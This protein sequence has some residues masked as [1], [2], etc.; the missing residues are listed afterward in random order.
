ML[1]DRDYMRQPEYH[2]PRVSWTIVLLVVNFVVFLVQLASQ[3]NPHNLL[4][5]DKYF[6]LSLAG[7]KTGYLWQLLTFQFMHEGWMHILFNSLAIFCFGRSVE[8]ILG[9]RRFLGIYFVSGVMGGVVQM[10]FALSI[11]SFDSAV[12][13]ASAGAA[14]LIGAFTIINWRESF[15]LILYF[16]PVTMTGRTFF[17]I[18]VGLS[19]LGILTPNSKIANAAHLGGILTGF[20]YARQILH[21]SWPQWTGFRRR[22]ER[23]RETVTTRAGEKKFWRSAPVEEEVSTDEFVQS[24]VDPILEKVFAHGMESLTARERE[25]LESARKKMTRP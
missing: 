12:V 19:M 15:T 7:I 16:I 17:W 6:A 18:S 24:K 2:A 8:T 10:L 25:I 9:A 11:H 14:G 13:G 3:Q 4:I 21:G 23:P 5:Q 1:E 22:E 20:L